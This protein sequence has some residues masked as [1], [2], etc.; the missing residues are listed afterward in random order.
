V[1][2]GVSGSASLTV[3]AL[4]VTRLVVTTQPGGATGGVNFATQ[5]VVQLRDVNGNPVGTATAAVTAAIASGAGTLSGTTTVSAV[6]G[7]A[8]FTD[9]RVDAPGSHTLVFS[10]PE[11]ATATSAVFTVAAGAT[12]AS[13]AIQTQ[14][15]GAV[16]GSAFSTQPVIR[17]LDSTGPWFP[18]PASPSPQRA[19][20]ARARSMA[21]RP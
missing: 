6:N 7:V 20:P 4:S 8:T 16:S 13:L 5:P 10:T 15:G 3:S 21:P 19:R 17:V 2:D 11:V 18:V 9:L 12:P 14:P 1:I